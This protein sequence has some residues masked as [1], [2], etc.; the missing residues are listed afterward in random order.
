LVSLVPVGD[1][2]A[3]VDDEDL[4][5]VEPY[6]WHLHPNNGKEYAATSISEKNEHGGSIRTYILMHRL[7][8]GAKEGE[9][10]YI[11]DNNGLNCT[12]KNL[13]KGPRNEADYPHP[14]SKYK[15]VSWDK[16][17]KKWIAHIRYEGKVIFLGSSY[18]ED[19]CKEAYDWA[20][21]QIRLGRPIYPRNRTSKYNNL[22][23]FPQLG[24]WCGVGNN[25]HLICGEDEDKLAKE[26]GGI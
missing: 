12:R 17:L 10:V 14:K 6:K 26:I 18:N 19:D 1:K 3:I 25:L 23:W 16:N 13:K 11:Q 5:T 22:Y 21:K 9:Y 8:T 7:I 15:G 4:T 20:T 24:K 2:H